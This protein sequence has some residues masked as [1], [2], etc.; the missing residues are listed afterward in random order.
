VGS[1]CMRLLGSQEDCVVSDGRAAGTARPLHSASC[2]RF[3]QSRSRLSAT[4]SS[5]S[6]LPHTGS[7]IFINLCT[8]SYESLRH[9]PPSLSL[10][11]LVDHYRFL[12]SL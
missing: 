9:N 5:V 6:T 11:L 8:S 12:R 3:E 10:P 7:S 2:L 1:V 4:L